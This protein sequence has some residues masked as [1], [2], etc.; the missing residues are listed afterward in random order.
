MCKV[1]DCPNPKVDL[2]YCGKHAKRFRK[3]GD[4]ETVQRT[5]RRRTEPQPIPKRLQ[6]LSEEEVRQ[7][8]TPPWW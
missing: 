1:E 5:G 8:T 4:T 7:A 6:G 3:Y 2:G